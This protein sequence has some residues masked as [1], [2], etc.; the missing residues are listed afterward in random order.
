[1]PRERRSLLVLAGVAVGGISV[2]HIACAIIGPA[3]YRY[4]GAGEHMASQAASGSPF[5]AIVTILL[6]LIFGAFAA[7]ALSAAGRIRPLP[8]VR[9][10][11]GVIGVIFAL[12]GMLLLP[13]LA[14]LVGRP[15]SIPPQDPVFSAVALVVG[16]LYLVGAFGRGAPRPS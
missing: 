4:L 13:E 14:M 15:A 7:Y 11:V 12:R 3:A 1:V 6:A 2:L 16:V 8:F 5:P 10:V 9:P